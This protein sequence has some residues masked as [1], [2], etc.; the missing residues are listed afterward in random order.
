MFI[1]VGK[2]LFKMINYY[3]CDPKDIICCICPSIR[4]CHFEVDED[5]K[6]LCEEIFKFTGKIEKFITVGE[7]KDGKQKYMID[8]IRINQ[9]LLTALG[10]KEK[11][12][13]DSN[14]CSVCHSDKIASYR[15]E[16]KNY[17]RATAVICL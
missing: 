9:L 2:V 13:I 11:N 17:Q 14:I 10:I 6:I 3:Q 8:T 12:I 7:I 15:V 5:V 16:G 4:K 1:L